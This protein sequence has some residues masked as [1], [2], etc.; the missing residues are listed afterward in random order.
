[1]NNQA[2]AFKSRLWHRLAFIW[3]CIIYTGGLFVNVE[4]WVGDGK[5][6]NF[7]VAKLD[8]A[9]KCFSFFQVVNILLPAVIAFTILMLCFGILFRMNMSGVRDRRFYWLSYSLQGTL[10]LAVA[11]VV[12]QAEIATMLCFMLILEATIMLHRGRF[13][14][15]VF[16]SSVLLF[17]PLLVMHQMLWKLSVPFNIDI[18]PIT[19][20]S[21]WWDLTGLITLVLL[22]SGYV[23]FYMRLMHS[24]THLEAA[25]KE[26]EAAHFQLRD[27][28]EQIESL[29][30]LMERQRLARELHDT[31]AQGLAGVMMQLQVASSRLTNQ[32]Y[33]RAQESVQQ[34]MTY[35]RSSLSTAR[36]VLD[37]LR[38]ESALPHELV[39]EVQEAIN[40][41]T[42]ATGIVCTYEPRALSSVP[43]QFHDH[44]LRVIAEGLANIAR[45]AEAS[46]VE[47][48]IVQNDMTLLIEVRDDGIGFDPTIASKQSGHYGLLGLRE[49]ARLIHGTFDLLSAP[50]KGTILSFH[51]PLLYEQTN[52]PD[53]LSTLTEEYIL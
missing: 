23:A 45:H 18:W 43:Y 27:S 51:F 1:M 25:H 19:P 3:L 31:L 47:I 41:F 37:D 22:V 26:L 16:V 2:G 14:G 29:T 4:A 10:I 30:R 20:I 39:E 32:R 9:N 28:A 5:S 48:S 34:A 50:G 40:R 52:M 53:S 11:F 12:S 21:S 15:M 17:I 44:V 38:S 33:E 36:N 8:T 35:V 49:R 24:H 13:S 42:V 7:C 6:G 46:H